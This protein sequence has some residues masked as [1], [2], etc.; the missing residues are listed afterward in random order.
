MQTGTYLFLNKT[1][2]IRCGV[3]VDFIRL[4]N[5][6]LAQNYECSKMSAKELSWKVYVPSSTKEV[7]AF[8]PVGYSFLPVP[9]IWRPRCRCNP[10]L[11]P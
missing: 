11:F 7:T 10:S 6:M 1:V 9:E 3:C 2:Y 5:K 8:F 4:R